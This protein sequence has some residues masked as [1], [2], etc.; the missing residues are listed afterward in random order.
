[1]I[2]FVYFDLG[3]VLY[4]FD[5]R[6]L[7]DTIRNRS[8]LDGDQLA[9]MIDDD[10]L[11]VRYEMGEIETGEFLHLV[12]QRFALEENIETILAAFN[13]IF[14]PLEANLGAALE[15]A[16]TLPCGIL[17]NTSEAHYSFLRPQHPFLHHPAVQSV[18]SFRVRVRKPDE[19]IYREAMRVASVEP[20]SILYLDDLG[21][22]VAAARELGWRAIQVEPG[23]NI[24]E[25][26]VE[27]GVLPAK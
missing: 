9:S 13:A 14:T 12:K 15:T 10:T 2:R 19:A 16:E 23:M 5:Y 4:D 20:E 24:R 18:L 11:M 7:Q 27:Y 22:N 17:S 3:K 6:P 26:L 21:P 25:V 8:R 1:M